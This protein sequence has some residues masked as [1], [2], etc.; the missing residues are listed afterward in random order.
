MRVI[1]IFGKE[2]PLGV[3]AL[4]LIVSGAG[5]AAGMATAGNI[6]GEATTVADQAIVVNSTD[7]GAII[8]KPGNLQV[9]SQGTQFRSAAQIYQGDSYQIELNLDHRGQTQHNGEMIL[10]AP[11]PIRLEAAGGDGIE[12]HQVAPDEWMFTMDPGTSNVTIKIGLPNDAQPDF[13]TIQGEIRSS[14]V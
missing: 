10:K 11:N 2:F 7:P 4:V 8:D 3:F 5:A 1:R 9:N 13:Y 12:M 14:E 6:V